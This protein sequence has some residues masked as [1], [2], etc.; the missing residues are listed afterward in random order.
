VVISGK[1]DLSLELVII[2]IIMEKV[3]YIA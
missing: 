2:V 1:S 3:T